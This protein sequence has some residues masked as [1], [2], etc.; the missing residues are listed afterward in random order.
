MT[1]SLPGGILIV[2]DE[3]ENMMIAAGI[4]REALDTEVVMSPTVEEAVELL[5]NRA[6][7]LVV[8]DLFIPLGAQ[9]HRVL[10]PRTRKYQEQ[11]EHLGGLIL[12][13][14]IERLAH[15]PVVVSHTAC[16]DAALHEV[17]GDRVARQIPKPAPFDSLLTGILSALG[18]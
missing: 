13:E 3:P 9:A 5:Q 10:G 14:E 1:G 7:A 15:R 17:F 2:D 12:L 8:M 16:T 11:V 18:R 6:W 4:L